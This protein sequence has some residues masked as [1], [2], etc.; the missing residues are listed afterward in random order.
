MCRALDLLRHHLESSTLAHAW[1]LVNRRTISV[2]ILELVHSLWLILLQWV[3]LRSTPTCT[4][5]RVST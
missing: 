5:A 4:T 2:V 1:E 3:R